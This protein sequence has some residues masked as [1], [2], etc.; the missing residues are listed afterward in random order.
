MSSEESP[1]IVESRL[2]GWWAH[3][4]Q[5][6][7]ARVWVDV[8]DIERARRIQIRK[9]KIEECLLK[10]RTERD[11]MERCQCPVWD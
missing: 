11:D 1:E 9:G 3:L 10:R 4:N 8:T 7:W 5:I 6:D 2:S